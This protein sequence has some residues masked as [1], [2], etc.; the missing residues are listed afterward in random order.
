MD[1][2]LIGSIALGAGVVGTAAYVYR[3]KLKSATN[4]VLTTF[5]F[6]PMASGPNIVFDVR[7]TFT[8]RYSNGGA[9]GLGFGNTA[10]TS[11]ADGGALSGNSIQFAA[12]NNLKAATWI[13]ELNTPNG[14][15]MSVLVRWKANYTG[16]PVAGR[17]IFALGGG[18]GIIRY[19]LGHNTSGNLIVNVRNETS[20]LAINSVSAGAWSPT[21]GTWYDIVMTWDGTTTASSCTVYVDAVSIGTITP[22]LALSSS[23]TNRYFNFIQVGW[24]VGI[25]G[26]VNGE[27]VDEIVIWD[28]VIDPT[29][30]TLDSGTGS[31]NGAS[32]V[33]LVAVS[34]LDGTSYTDPGI[35]NVKSGVSYTYAGT[36][37]TGTLAST[38]ASTQQICGP[39]AMWRN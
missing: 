37:Q 16:S 9:T 24:G 6:S 10:P 32:R 5:G 27:R 29:S 14:R 19:E 7:G 31:L 26:I 34:A 18:G 35:A 11:A 17:Q 25:N 39:G 8:A 12:N 33:S 22:A 2:T 23:W 1:A 15:A 30:V 38:S 4:S 36:S 13:G 28:G 3:N 20:G 21:S